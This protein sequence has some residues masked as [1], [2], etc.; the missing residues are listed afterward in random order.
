MKW[1]ACCLLLLASPVL[2]AQLRVEETE[3]KI[4]LST[5]QLDAA[6]NKK[7]YVSGIAGGSLLDK[8]TGFRDAGFGLDIVDWIMQPGSDEAYRNQLDK[9]LVYAINNEYHGKIPKR[10][11]EGPQI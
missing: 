5:A 9:E 7:G 11:I 8:Q 6:I 1:L 3:Q 2:R 4:T 10:S